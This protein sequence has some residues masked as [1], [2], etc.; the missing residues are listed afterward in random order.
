MVKIIELG[1]IVNLTNS[2]SIGLVVSIKNNKV[3]VFSD[4]YYNNWC[5]DDVDAPRLLHEDI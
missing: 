4:K 2:D 3:F 1:D 5:W